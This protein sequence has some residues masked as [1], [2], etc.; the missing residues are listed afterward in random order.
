[1]LGL[2]AFTIEICAIAVDRFIR[3]T[4]QPMHTTATLPFAKTLVPAS[5]KNRNAED[6][7]PH[8]HYPLCESERAGVA[9]GLQALHDFKD[10]PE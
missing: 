10:E 4:V 2:L 6:P 1:M 3:T 5:S 7:P 8:S 9:L